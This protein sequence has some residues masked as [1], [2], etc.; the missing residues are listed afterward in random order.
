MNH[1]RLQKEAFVSKIKKIVRS[2]SLCMYVTY[3]SQKKSSENEKQ[4]SDKLMT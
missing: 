3:F 2:A 4:N 1:L